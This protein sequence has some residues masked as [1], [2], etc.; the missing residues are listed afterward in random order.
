MSTITFPG[1]SAEYRAARDRLLDQEKEL[2]LNLEAVAKAR[3]AL[4]PGGVIPEDYVFQGRGPNGDQVDVRMSELFTPGRDSLLI[5]NFMYGPEAEQ[6]CP[7]CTGQLD[8]LNGI[9]DH[10]RDRVNLAIVAKSP[11]PRILE[12]AD[13]RD[14]SRMPFLSS[15]HNSY[16]K[17]YFGLAPDGSWEG[18]ITNVFHREGDTIRHFWGSELLYEPTEPGQAFRHNDTMHP[19]W[20]LLDFT[21]EGRGV[22]MWEPKLSYA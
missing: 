4:P 13:Q 10:V 18:P 15:E 11:L 2:R 14:W 21:P 8:A 1:E 12:Y 19:L 20:G 16:N 22:G 17:D 7:G 9:A 3:R 5:Y 6:P